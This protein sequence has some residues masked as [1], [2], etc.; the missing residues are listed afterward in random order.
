[1]EG[2][3]GRKRLTGKASLERSFR[4]V[5]NY[6]VKLFELASKIL[7]NFCYVICPFLQSVLTILKFN[8]KKEES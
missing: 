7:F 4:K 2:R 5:F 8:D 1:M 6:D 3:S